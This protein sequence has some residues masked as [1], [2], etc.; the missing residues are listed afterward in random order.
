MKGQGQWA[1]TM[2]TEADQQ[3]STRSPELKPLWVPVY[4]I[5][6]A[7]YAQRVMVGGAAFLLTAVLAGIGL[8]YFEL[9]TVMAVLSFSLATAKVL[10]ELS[11]NLMHRSRQAQAGQT[12][13][14]AGEE[15]PEV[16]AGG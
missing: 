2:A 16:L 6:G 5:S 13:L 12:N 1:E 9:P 3:G 14:Q 7:S 8:R 10:S 11:P 4:Q 15:P